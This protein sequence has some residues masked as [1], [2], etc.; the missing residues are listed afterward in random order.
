[1]SLFTPA[2]LQAPE[3]KFPESN[4]Y[5]YCF[6]STFAVDYLALIGGLIFALISAKSINLDLR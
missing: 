3:S 2:D 1:M 4:S 6:Q 5:F